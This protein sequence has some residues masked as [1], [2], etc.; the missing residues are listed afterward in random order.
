MAQI[1]ISYAREDE[2]EVNKLYWKLRD[3]GFTPWMDTE[4]IL[5]GEDWERAI[6]KALRDSHFIIVCLSAKF[7]AKR[8]FIQREIKA[9]ADR[10]QEMMGGDILTIPA[11]LEACE[12]PEEFRQRQWVDLFKDNGWAKL[13]RA[14]QV[15][16]ERRGI[17]IASAQSSVQSG[18]KK[19]AKEE[20]PPSRKTSRLS[21]DFTTVTLDARGEVVKRRQ[22]TAR[23]FKE[24]AGGID[25]EMVHVP[26]GEFAMGTNAAEAVEVRKEIERYW[27]DSGDW[28]NKE[29]PQHEVIVPDFYIGKFQVTQA[30]WR[31]VARWPKVKIDLTLDPSNFK[32]DLLPVEQVSW[33]DAQEFCAR[34]TKKTGKLYRLPNEAE[35]EYAC[36][37]GTMTPFAFGETITTEFVNCDGNNPYAG[38]EKGEFRKQT[39]PVGSLGVANAFGLFD[40]HGNVWEWCQDV[41]HESY[42]SAPRDGSAW[43]SGG[44]SSLRVLRGG[45]WYDD[46]RNCRA[47]SRSWLAPGLITSV[48]GVRVVFARTP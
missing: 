44:D 23:Y 17:A 32:G 29:L 7:L 35:W 22:G 14:L 3:A 5:P 43:L 8:G 1:F 20:M 38:T 10:L 42:D 18:E 31:T 30:Q 39:S 4:D 28:V 15:G 41:W 37:A 40:L 33:A 9:S 27:K 36:R 16:A 13:L 46:S 2:E 21:Y 48:I 47:A 19:D 26:G 34:L 25:M 11:R 6:H 45:S 12:V 24:E